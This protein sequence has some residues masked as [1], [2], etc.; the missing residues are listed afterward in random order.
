MR[1]CVIFL[2][3]FP[4]ELHAPFLQRKCYT[5]NGCTAQFEVG[6][7]SVCS[8]HSATTLAPAEVFLPMVIITFHKYPDHKEVFHSGVAK[9]GKA[10]F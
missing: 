2:L 10:S 7:G 4:T 1:E 9:R 6:F 8:I 3:T 5:F